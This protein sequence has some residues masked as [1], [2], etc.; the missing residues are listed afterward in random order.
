VPASIVDGQHLHVFVPTAAVQ[1]LVFDAQVGEMHLVV[2]V[3]EVVLERPLRNLLRVAVGVPVVVVALAI[4]V[5][6][7]LLVLALELEIEEDP[8]DAGVALRQALR[9]AFERAVDLASRVR[10]PARV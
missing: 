5:V 1:L 4:P 9:L 6:Q 3:R 10:V 7:P 8:F 2:E